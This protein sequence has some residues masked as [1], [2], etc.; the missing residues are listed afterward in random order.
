MTGST[1]AESGVVPAGSREPWKSLERARPAASLEER[2]GAGEE[3]GAL[4][5]G[6]RWI[7][8]LSD[9]GE[10]GRGGQ[11]WAGEGHG[12]LQ[13][14]W[15]SRAGRGPACRLLPSPSVPTPA[16]PTGRAAEAGLGPAAWGL[17][18]R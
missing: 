4:V 1:Q 12:R 3:A 16:R 2:T 14:E 6:D 5:A 18:L 17:V 15:V 7:A 10:V 8:S 9:P 13:G 11:G